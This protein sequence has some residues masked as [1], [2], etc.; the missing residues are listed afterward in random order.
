MIENHRCVCPICEVE[1]EL[2]SL[3]DRP[4][5]RERFRIGKTGFPVLERFSSPFELLA[6]LH[7]RNQKVNQAPTADQILCALIRATLTSTARDILQN[8]FILAFMPAI[9]RTV[10]AIRFSFPGLL[11]EDIAQQVLTN[12]LEIAGSASIERR[13]RHLSVA[14]ARSLRKTAFRWAIKE[15]RKSADSQVFERLT[16]DISQ[17]FADGNFE[18]SL[19]LEE[20]LSQ[21]CQ[22]GIL[23]RS[24]Y[25]LLTK[26]KLEGF[27]AREVAGTRGEPYPAAVRARLYRIMKRLRQAAVA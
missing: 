2:A 19:M 9:H 14:I 3:L 8:V 26:V 21:C 15:A 1:R 4:I 24:G 10:R 5:N 7:N 25:E 18:K 23:S 12:F 17:L 22:S 11:P 27:E 6:H 16:P 20:F 13:T